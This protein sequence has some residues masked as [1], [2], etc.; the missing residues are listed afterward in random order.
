MANPFILVN[1]SFLVIIDVLEVHFDAKNNNTFWAVGTV[2]NWNDVLV[3]MSKIGTIG[4]TTPLLLP[5]WWKGIMSFYGLVSKIM[6][7][8]RVIHFWFLAKSRELKRNEYISWF[9]KFGIKGSAKFHHRSKT[10][11]SSIILRGN[12]R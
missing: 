4:S 3:Q 11:I 10:C 6:L 5:F 2:S 8:E 12:C 9:T 1:L 7:G